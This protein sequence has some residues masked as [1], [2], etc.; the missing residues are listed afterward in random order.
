MFCALLFSSSHSVVLCVLQIIAVNLPLDEISGMREI[1]SEI[2]KDKS[3][4]ITVQEFA[5]ALRKKG[6]A[7]PEAEVQRIM[8]VSNHGKAT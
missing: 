2:D 6:Q 1:F 3:G 5:D 7:I 4:T 8:T